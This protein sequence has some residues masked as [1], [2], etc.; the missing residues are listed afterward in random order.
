MAT[1]SIS[2]VV[3]A[4]L[5]IKDSTLDEDSDDQSIVVHKKPN[6]AT[7]EESSDS[8]SMLNQ[9]EFEDKLKKIY[10]NLFIHALEL[11]SNYSIVYGYFMISTNEHLLNPINHSDSFTNKLFALMLSRYITTNKDQLVLKELYI[12]YFCLTEEFYND[13]NS[14]K[15]SID[16]NTI[17]NPCYRRNVFNNYYE[18]Y[19]N[20]V[21]LHNLK[22][23]I[24]TKHPHYIGYQAICESN[25]FIRNIDLKTISD[26]LTLY[27]LRTIIR[28]KF[29][30]GSS[31]YFEVVN[32][33]KEERQKK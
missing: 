19:S 17:L 6:R 30:P 2:S 12:K 5:L 31:E 11:I 3:D 26:D 16:F 32:A 22:K 23:L 10:K 9:M 20:G 25:E 13:T 18:N 27:I 1:P 4:L 21:R 7:F 29:I 28:D 8:S 15:L 14:T 33:Y 24:E